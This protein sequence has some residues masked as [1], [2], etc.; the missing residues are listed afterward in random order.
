MRVS[1]NF[2]QESPEVES[3]T[4]AP[5][6]PA[7]DVKE[8][9]GDVKVKLED[10]KPVVKEEQKPVVKKDEPSEEI[11]PALATTPVKQE[12]SEQKPPF[13]APAIQVKKDEPSSSPV[14]KELSEMA[15]A[16]D[17]VN[18]GGEPEALKK[19]VSFRYCTV[20]M[21][22]FDKDAGERQTRSF[23]NSA[24]AASSST[25]CDGANRAD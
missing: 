3:P 8:E 22:S 14:A 13:E 24:T 23:A 19:D 21:C 10:T 2:K 4:K 5:T 18:M 12:P 16:N 17:M 25:T 9:P 1:V 7:V 15:S 6:A 20:E 11:K